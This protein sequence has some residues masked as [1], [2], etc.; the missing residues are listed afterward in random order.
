MQVSVL[1]Y[2]CDLKTGE[3][4]SSMEK[5]ILLTVSI[6]FSG[7]VEADSFR[8]GRK[9]VKPGDSSNS[10]IKKCGKPVRKYSSREMVSDQ[11]RQSKVAVSNWVYERGRGKDMIVSVRSGT[12][13][14]TRVD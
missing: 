13:I 4:N 1:A 11:G 3:D 14:K 8:C 12:V 6:L 10:L 5:L 7:I 2:S 9:I